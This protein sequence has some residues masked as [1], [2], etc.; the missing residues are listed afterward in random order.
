L[1]AHSK[2]HV[3][4]VVGP[5]V[6]G[7]F[8][9]L[10]PG[11]APFVYES[12]TAVHYP[13]EPATG[14]PADLVAQGAVSWWD[15]SSNEHVQPAR[16]CG[17]MSGSFQFWSV[18]RGPRPTV[19]LAQLTHIR[20]HTYTMVMYTHRSILPSTAHGPFNMQTPPPSN[21]PTFD[22][23]VAPFRLSC[24]PFLVVV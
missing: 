6:V 13:A 2:G 17:V 20:T 16:L 9:R 18:P 10:V 21:L 22:V 7:C 11:G 4:H 19:R 3:D 14:L 1:R 24:L 8:P 15:G 5:G 23:V 12:Q